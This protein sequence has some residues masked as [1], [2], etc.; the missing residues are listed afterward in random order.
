MRC[1]VACLGA[2]ASSD[3]NHCGSNSGII[4]EVTCQAHTIKICEIVPGHKMNRDHLSHRTYHRNINQSF[5]GG[6]K[7]SDEMFKLCFLNSVMS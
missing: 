2:E 1:S 6:M 3:H 7:M 4:S 5:R